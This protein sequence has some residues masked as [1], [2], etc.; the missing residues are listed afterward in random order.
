[1]NSTQLGLFVTLIENDDGPL[2]H[3]LG[4]AGPL[5]WKR[6]SG[7]ADWLEGCD[8]F[9]PKT[10]T[11]NSKSFSIFLGLIQNQI[12]FEFERFLNESK[13]EHSINSK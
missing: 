6:K 12:E 10:S 5:G 9:R 7:P 8:G 2:G 1:M 11:V 3:T 4:Q 13:L